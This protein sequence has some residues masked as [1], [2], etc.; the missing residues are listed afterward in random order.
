MFSPVS[1]VVHGVEFV[2]GFEVH[3]FLLE[4]EYFDDYGAGHLR[5]ENWVLIVTTCGDFG[6]GLEVGGA[7]SR[8]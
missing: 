1:G 5:Q 3:S 8:V 7:G 2:Q 6:I 4:H